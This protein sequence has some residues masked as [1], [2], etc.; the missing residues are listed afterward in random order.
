L[1]RQYDK[2]DNVFR[3]GVEPDP[4]GFAVHLILFYPR[5]RSGRPIAGMA[6]LVI[7][8]GGRSEEISFAEY[9]VGKTKV[10]RFYSENLKLD[11]LAA[12]TSIRLSGKGLPEVHLASSGLG[13]AILVLKEC[14]DDLLRKWGYDPV[15]LRNIATPAKPI[16]DTR[17]WFKDEDYPALALKKIQSGVTIARADID[18]SGKLLTCVVTQ[19][20]GSKLLDDQTC[21]LALERA[22]YTPALARD[23]SAV[24][25][26]RMIRV[27]WGI[28]R[29]F[30]GLK[31][32]R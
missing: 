1:S 7:E 5:A 15:V 29:R 31:L 16:G 2:N 4:T 22:R 3:F 12:A 6:K 26:V 13:R 32:S 9:L 10:T 11:S 21:R 27:A 14:A 25:S 28:E 24:A 30:S 23:G 19:G 20:S 8:P 18:S 17:S